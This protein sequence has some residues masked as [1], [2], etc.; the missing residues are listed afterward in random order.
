MAW[1]DDM[2]EM[3]RVLVDDMDEPP[4][5]SDE[6]LLRVLTVA[7]FQ[8]SSQL[9]F[10]HNFAVSISAQTISPDPTAAAY[11][12]PSFLNLTTTKAACIINQGSAMTAAARAIVVRD[13]GSMVDLRAIFGA[14]FKL[15]E[16]GWCAV[17]EDMKFEYQAGSVRVAGAAVLG[18]FRLYARGGFGWGQD[19]YLGG[20]RNRDIIN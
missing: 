20:G 18:P 10:D 16:Q 14:K 1:E 4:V 15:I 6:K 11:S 5:F 2:T 13:G 9:T 17:Y 7:A 12:N 8:V 3:L 19:G